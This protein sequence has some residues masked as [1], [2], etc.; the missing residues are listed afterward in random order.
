LQ[1]LDP[2]TMLLQQRILFLGSQVREF[3][4]SFPSFPSLSPSAEETN[5][6]QCCCFFVGLFLVH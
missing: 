6:W 2:S 3:Y 4:P 1:D 5:S